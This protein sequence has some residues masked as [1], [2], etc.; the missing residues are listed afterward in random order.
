[1]VGTLLM[2]PAFMLC[3]ESFL[4]PAN[5]AAI[6]LVFLLHLA[7]ENHV[8]GFSYVQLQHVFAWEHALTFLANRPA[9]TVHISEDLHVELEGIHM[10]STV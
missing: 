1:M 2:L 3:S 4:A 8:M 5:H 7:T 9:D 6:H 10:S